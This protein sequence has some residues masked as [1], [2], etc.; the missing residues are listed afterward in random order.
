MNYSD[1]LA[2]WNGRQCLW[3]TRNTCRFI[4]CCLQLQR[5]ADLRAPCVDYL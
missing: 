2:S 3:L 4:H 1:E 5:L